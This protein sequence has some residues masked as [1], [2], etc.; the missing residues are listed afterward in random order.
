[1]ACNGGG[2]QSIVESK[3]MKLDGN[4]YGALSTSIESPHSLTGSQKT[5][6]A[7]VSLGAG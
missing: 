5:S 1:M 3:N 4:M 2:I 7:L 6:C